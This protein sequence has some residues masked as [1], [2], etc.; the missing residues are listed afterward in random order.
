MDVELKCSY[1]KCTESIGKK[2]QGY[3]L[4]TNG[5]CPGCSECMKEMFNRHEKIGDVLFEAQYGRVQNPWG[6]L[7]KMNN[8]A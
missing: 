6:N 5:H 8:D 3:E 4:E 7:R 2:L 1:G